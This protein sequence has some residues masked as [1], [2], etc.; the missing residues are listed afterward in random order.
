MELPVEPAPLTHKNPLLAISSPSKTLSLTKFD[1]VFF[2][3]LPNTQTLNF[4]II[5]Q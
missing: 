1:E 4:V 3:E 2:D 5:E